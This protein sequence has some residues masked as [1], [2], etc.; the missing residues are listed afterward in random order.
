MLHGGGSPRW[1]PVPRAGYRSTTAADGS[2][3]TIIRRPVSGEDVRKLR[4]CVYA[5]LAKD[6][7]HV[8]LDRTQGHEERLG[9]LAVREAGRC[10]RRD[11][12][13]ARRQRV[14]AAHT[15]AT[16]PSAGRDQLRMG[17]LGNPRSTT[18]LGEVERTAQRLSGL[19]TPVRPAESRPQLG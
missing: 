2:G 17:E 1:P 6:V 7:A 11:A 15:P 4:A 18:A 3:G 14:D 19:R 12:A 8:H 5:E 16:R 10:H 13:F 9:D